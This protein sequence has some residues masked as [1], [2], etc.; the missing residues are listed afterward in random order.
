MTFWGGILTAA[1]SFPLFWLIDTKSPVAI[2]LAITVGIMLVTIAYAVSGALLAELFPAKLRY[3]GVA[4]GYNIAGATSGFLPLIATA[5]LTVSNN[6]SWGAALILVI[7]ALLTA[8]GGHF[9]E[10]LRVRD[11]PIVVDA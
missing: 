11:K 7:I 1:A 6:A 2:T 10:K 5:M 3:S 8:V 4:L 9:G